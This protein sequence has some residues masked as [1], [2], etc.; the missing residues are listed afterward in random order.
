MQEQHVIKGEQEQSVSKLERETQINRNLIYSEKYVRA[1]QSLGEGKDCTRTI[2]ELSRMMLEHRNGSLYEDL[3]YVDSLNN[4]YLAQTMYS[5]KTQSVEPTKNMQRMLC[6]NPNI[7]GIHNHPKSSLPSLDDIH[8]C[9]ERNYKY[10]IVLCHN[11]SIY[12]YKNI[13]PI[14]DINILGAY[15]I[16]EKEEYETLKN[17]QTYSDILISH[18][19]HLEELIFNLNCAGVE[20]EEVLYNER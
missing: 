2:V 19:E 14:I 4:K 18:K 20:F 11:G 9:E 6:N 10:G 3:Y 17:M 5:D 13:G 12:K 8:V 15:S 1:I 7:I 16:Y